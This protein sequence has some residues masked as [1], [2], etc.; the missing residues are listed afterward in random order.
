MP[1]QEIAMADTE[2]PT[3]VAVLASEAVA[4]I[5]EELRRRLVAEVGERDALAIETALMKAYI[6]GMRTGSAGASE[7]VLERVDADA[8][9]TLAS[10]PIE[11]AAELDPQLPWL[12]PWADRYGDGS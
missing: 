2:D 7:S 8:G 6:N 1:A 9:P 11:L 5:E 4:P 10:N 3:G 12:D